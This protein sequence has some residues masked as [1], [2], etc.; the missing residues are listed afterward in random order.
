MMQRAPRVYFSPKTGAEFGSLL[1]NSQLPL[2]VGTGY[3]QKSEYWF[4]YVELRW[5]EH[6]DD[7]TYSSDIAAWTVISEIIWQIVDLR[8]RTDALDARIPAAFACTVLIRFAFGLHFHNIFQ[9]WKYLE[10]DAKKTYVIAS[11]IAARASDKGATF[12]RAI[13]V[14]IHTLRQSHWHSKTTHLLC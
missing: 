13:H 10:N 6:D 2:L 4:V 11:P 5:Q 8:Q 7:R 3:G 12:I 14:L 9:R 1:E